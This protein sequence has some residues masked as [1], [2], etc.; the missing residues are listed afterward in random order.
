MSAIGE[1]KLDLLARCLVEPA[2]DVACNLLLVRT[3][4]GS[5][6]V[7]RGARC[8]Q[9]CQMVRAHGRLMGHGR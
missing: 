2:V 3:G 5:P 1:V 7:I 6:L 4:R 9:R 8:Q